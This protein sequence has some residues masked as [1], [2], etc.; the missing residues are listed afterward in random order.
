MMYVHLHKTADELL[1]T[2]SPK[3]YL[4]KLLVSIISL[5]LR[6]NEL[7]GVHIRRVIDL[8]SICS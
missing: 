6:T 2:H 3:N 7:F 1:I 8:Y 4:K 5:A